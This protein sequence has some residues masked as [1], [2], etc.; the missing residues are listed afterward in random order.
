MR[1]MTGLALSIAALFVLAACGQPSGGPPDEQPPS[2]DEVLIPDTTKVLDAEARTALVDVGEDGT[3]RFASSAGVI[4]DLE[5][6][7]VIASEPANAAPNGL[8][9]KVVSVREEGGQTVVETTGAEIREAIH[10]GSLSVSIDLDEADLE[11]SLA[12]QS[13]VRVQGL[14]HDLDTDFGTDGR[15][16]ATGTVEIDPVLDFDMGISCDR[17]VL[18]VC[19]EIP[20]LNV[21]VKLG[22][23]ESADVALEGEDATDFDEEFPIALHQFS[24]ITFS[25]GPVP[26]VLTPQLEI[27][28][29]AEGELSASLSFRTTQELTLAG[30][31][32]FD[33]DAG[34]RNISERSTDFEVRT[35]DVEASAEARA[36]VGGRYQVH[37]YGVIGPFGALEAGPSL[38][39]D[40]QGLPGRGDLIYAFEGCL[41]GTVGINS[42]DVLD[43]QYDAELF[44]L[45]TTFAEEANSDPSV[46]IGLP[47]EDSEIFDS[48]E[49]T[50]RANTFDRDDHDVTCEWTSSRGE[51]PLAGVGCEGTT[52][53]SSLGTRT[54]TV[55][56]TDPFGA[57]DTD[58]VTVDV[59]AAPFILVQIDQPT[60]DDDFRP[61]DTITLEGSAQGGT[62]PHTLEWSGEIE[63]SDVQQVDIGT[64]SSLTWTPEDDLAFD[65]C[66]QGDDG[67]IFELTLTATD[68]EGRTEARSIEFFIGHI[69]I[70]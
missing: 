39:A 15:V 70:E 1:T 60:E 69:C 36:F 30:G 41:T 19:A 11:E 44:D 45:C 28:L 40:L 25:I 42:V 9:R 12:L 43:L 35:I 33:S 22:V 6:D 67:G 4:A 57:T 26:V 24:P 21:L 59:E 50:L 54:L 63:M 17:K 58:S 2:E 5:T 16:R 51:D 64:G 68:A 7:D 13:G 29:G 55:T 62:E 18:G 27:Y 49:T 8:L 34:F 48:E 52:T 10:Q 3:L 56:A 66:F 20:D 37:L 53:F 32:E 61:D 23:E 46:T 47:Q 38:E 14:R 65:D 31:F